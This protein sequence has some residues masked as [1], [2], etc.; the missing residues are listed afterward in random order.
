MQTVKEPDMNVTPQEIVKAALQLPE[1]D[2]LAVV[3]QLLDSLPTEIADLNEEEFHAELDRRSR[4]W[5]GSVSWD[6]LKAGLSDH[7]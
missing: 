3:S 5:D 6:E 1:R 4:D 2:R 7:S